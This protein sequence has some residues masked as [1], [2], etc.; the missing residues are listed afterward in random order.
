MSSLA[1]CNDYKADN[2]HGTQC[3]QEECYQKRQSNCKADVLVIL[4]FTFWGDA[5]FLGDIGGL[6][7]SGGGGLGEIGGGGLGEIG[8]GGLGEIGRELGNIG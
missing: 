3:C 1:I 6:G 5:C 4:L 2:D 8:C 7:E